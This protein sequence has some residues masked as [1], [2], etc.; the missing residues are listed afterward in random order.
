MTSQA[1]V[2]W[3]DEDLSVNL[4]VDM[5]LSCVTRGF[6]C[7]ERGGGDSLFS[8]AQVE[9]SLEKENL[10]AIKKKVKIKRSLKK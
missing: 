5:F 3:S 1:S 6:S 8:A 9:P 2:L 7:L 10:A 4:R